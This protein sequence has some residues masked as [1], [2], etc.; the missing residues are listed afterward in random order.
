MLRPVNKI[1]SRYID[2]EINPE[3]PPCRPLHIG[4]S[5]AALLLFLLDSARTV[6]PLRLTKGIF[7]FTMEA[8]DSWLAKQERYQFIPYNY[9]PYSQ[10]LRNDLDRLVEQ[11]DVLASKV[12][13]KN[14]DYYY[15]SKKGK[16]RAQEAA[17]YLPTEA[18]TYLRKVR[19]YVLRVSVRK[20]LDT[21]YDRYP[22]YAV[23]NV[24]KR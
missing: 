22:S 11:R 14:W 20:L 7:I 1:R 12:R 21:V 5:Q 15:L 6:D 9:G 19:K 24:F 4:K 8:P 13:D 16:K 23:K 10:S 17:N 18:V 3:R 2:Q